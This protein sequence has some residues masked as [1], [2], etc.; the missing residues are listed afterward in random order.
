M[1]LSHDRGRSRELLSV[2]GI[3]HHGRE[4][5]RTPCEPGRGVDVKYAPPVEVVDGA[6]DQ[7]KAIRIVERGT[8][9]WDVRKNKYLPV[10][11]SQSPN[12]RK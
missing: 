1:M 6:D 2:D 8:Y 4:I 7:P 12:A 10:A 3:P 5:S 9:L 11:Q